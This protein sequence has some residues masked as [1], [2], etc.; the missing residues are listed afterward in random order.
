M[1]SIALQKANS[2]S[3]GSDAEEISMKLESL[4]HEASNCA[5]NFKLLASSPLLMQLHNSAQRKVQNFTVLLETL[6]KSDV[7]KNVGYFIRSRET[8]IPDYCCE[9]NLFA[10][11]CHKAVVIVGII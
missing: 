11:C 8:F 2:V 5:R 3:D 9:Q 4:Y 10:P 6:L 7:H 1:H